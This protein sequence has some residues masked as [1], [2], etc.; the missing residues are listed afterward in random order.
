M[1]SFVIIVLAPLPI[2][3]SILMTDA[4]AENNML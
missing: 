1:I 4:E 2:W 3:Y